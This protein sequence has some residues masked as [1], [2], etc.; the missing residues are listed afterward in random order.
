MRQRNKILKILLFSMIALEEAY[1]SYA[2]STISIAINSSITH[3]STT[4]TSRI[5][6]STSSTMMALGTTEQPEDQEGLFSTPARTVGAIYAI[7]FIALLLLYACIA[8]SRDQGGGINCSDESTKEDMLALLFILLWPIMLLTG[9]SYACYYSLASNSQNNKN[10]PQ[11]AEKQ[12][13]STEKIAIDYLRTHSTPPINQREFS[14]HPQYGYAN[15]PLTRAVQSGDSEEVIRLLNANASPNEPNKEGITPVHNAA[16][17]QQTA[18][19]TLL[20]QANGDVNQKSKVGETPLHYSAAGND[21]NIVKILLKNSAKIF[22]SGNGETPLEKVR[23]YN[24]EKITP[25]NEIILNLLINHEQRQ[26]MP[27]EEV[28]E[29]FEITGGYTK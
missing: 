25:T 10:D 7:G 26:K 17:Y 5:T 15:P 14:I 3:T 27:E 22:K 18:I 21:S 12:Q 16:C 28:F 4:S 8:S 2:N 24:R 1:L 19:L 6:T 20:I 9:L 13:P 23:R 11:N 29:G